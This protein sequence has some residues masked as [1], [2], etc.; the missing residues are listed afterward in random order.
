[1]Y[2]EIRPG[3]SM[4]CSKSSPRALLWALG[5]ALTLMLLVSASSTASA[6][7]LGGYKA[8]AEATLAEL[9]AKRLANSKATLARLDEMVALGIVGV[10]EYSAHH[11]Q[12]AKLMDAVVADSQAMKGMTDVAL[13]DKWGETGTGGDAVGIP[14]KSL[15]EHGQ[16]R[17]YIE[18][19]VGPAQQYILVKQ[20]QSTKKARWLEQARGEAVELLKHLKEMQSE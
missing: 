5:A 13:E 11:P 6:F 16:E 1:V 9:N 3:L 18:L 17:D 10:R 20:W 4:A 12:Y 2:R 8:R 14:L 19:V 15:P 7:D